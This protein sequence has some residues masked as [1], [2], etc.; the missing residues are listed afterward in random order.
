M[1]VSQIATNAP[2]ATYRANLAYRPYLVKNEWPPIVWPGEYA[3][4]AAEFSDV[5]ALV[6]KAVTEYYTDVILG[7]K[8]LEADWDAY[9]RSLD[10]IGLEQYLELTSLY[11]TGGR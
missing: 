8:N 10:E 5:N 4:K 1:D 7:R 6:Q 3:D 9:V 11:I 2:L